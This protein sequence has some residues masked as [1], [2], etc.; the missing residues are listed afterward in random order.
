MQ[1]LGHE[2]VWIGWHGKCNSILQKHKIET[3]QQEMKLVREMECL[4]S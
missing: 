2:R 3:M 4:V 1:E